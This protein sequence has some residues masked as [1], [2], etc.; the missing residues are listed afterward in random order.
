[1][2]DKELFTIPSDPIKWPSKLVSLVFETCIKD[3]AV[4]RHQT[5]EILGQ[6]MTRAAEPDTYPAIKD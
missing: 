1:M 6:L 3:A 4:T 2:S 5:Q